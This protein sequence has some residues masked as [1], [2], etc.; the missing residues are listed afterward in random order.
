MTSVLRGKPVV[1]VG[2]REYGNDQLE[3]SGT[4]ATYFRPEDDMAAP[5]QLRISE[6]AKAR[7]PSV[8][9]SLHYLDIKRR[10]LRIKYLRTYRALY[11]TALYSFQL[12]PR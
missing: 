8:N 7:R 3:R 1:L 4:R 12:F 11:S 2:P 6:S 5:H 10:R 9:F